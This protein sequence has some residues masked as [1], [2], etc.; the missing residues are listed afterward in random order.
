MAYIK[1]GIVSENVRDIESTLLLIKQQLK[2]NLRTATSCAGCFISSFFIRASVLAIFLLQLSPAQELPQPPARGSSRW[3]ADDQRG[4]SNL[5]T[6]NKVLEASRLIRTGQIISLGRIYEE[7]MPQVSGRTYTLVIPQ[8]APP[9]GRNRIVGHD[10]F[11]ASQI[12]QV[13]T[14]LDALGHVGIG[15]IFYNGNNRNEFVTG[16]GLSK[17]GIE[18][19]GPF[20]T[21]G[22]LL[23]IAA[24]KGKTRLEKG[25]E[26]TADDLQQALAKEKLE[27]RPGDAVILHTGWGALWKVD[28]ALYASGEPGIGISAA[29]FLASQQISLVGADTWGVDVSPNPVPDLMFPAHQILI[30]LNGIHPLENLDTSQLA[31][32]KVWEFAFFLAPLKLKGATGSPGNPVAIQ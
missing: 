24:L 28:N 15:D 16:K 22:L 26:I 9:A 4:A 32:E 10:E 6:P 12:G 5:I 18:N 21:R 20:F 29:K 19:A 7:S 31:Q 8:P 30:T 13:G 1:G 2:K 17:L 23:D 11:V 14:Q 25:Y 27:I 3:G